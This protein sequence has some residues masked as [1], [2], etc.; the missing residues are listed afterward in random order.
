MKLRDAI[1]SG[2][3]INQSASIP[4][5]VVR[6]DALAADHDRRYTVNRL[7]GGGKTRTLLHSA[8]LASVESY[9]DAET[10]VDPDAWRGMMY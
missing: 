7:D 2:I 6:A 8:D 3:A 5:E 9:I 1:A 10:D 4:I